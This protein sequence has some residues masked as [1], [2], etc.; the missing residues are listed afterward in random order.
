MN[1]EKFRSCKNPICTKQESQ[2]ILRGNPYQSHVKLWGILKEQ[3][4]Y[5]KSTDLREMCPYSTESKTSP[6]Q[7]DNILQSL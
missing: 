3:C 4:L 1:N 2:M 7:T 5:S 6:D